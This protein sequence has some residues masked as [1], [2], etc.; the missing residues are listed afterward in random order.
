M[1]L[2]TIVVP[3]EDGM[4]LAQVIARTLMA[5][6]ERFGRDCDD[7]VARMIGFKDP[8]HLRRR[9]R[10]DPPLWHSHSRGVASVNMRFGRKWVNL[11]FVRTQ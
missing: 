1:P 11:A 10:V 9:L 5:A 6:V 7:A 4:F 2:F 8:A 3:I